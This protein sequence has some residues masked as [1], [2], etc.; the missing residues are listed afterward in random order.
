MTCLE[1]QKSNNNII[2]NTSVVSI[3]VFVV[4]NEIFT[5]LSENNEWREEILAIFALLSFLYAFIYI[6][7]IYPHMK[8]F[9]IGVIGLAFWAIFQ[10]VLIQDGG[11]LVFGIKWGAALILSLSPLLVIT[12]ANRNGYRYLA[13]NVALFFAEIYIALQLLSSYLFNFGETYIYSDGSTRAFGF[14][15]DSISPVIAFFV[16]K[17]LLEHRHYRFVIAF[18]CLMITGGK[19]AII[20]AIIMFF[21]MLYVCKGRKFSVKKYL[22]LGFVGYLILQILSISLSEGYENKSSPSSSIA[23][24]IFD[25]GYLQKKLSHLYGDYINAGGNR[26]FSIIAAIEIF[27]QN[28]VVGIGV[29][30]SMGFISSLDDGFPF[31][32]DFSISNADQ[33]W[34]GVKQI[35]NPTFRIMAEMG[36]IGLF[37]FWLVC[38]GILMIPFAYIRR[39]RKEKNKP[40]NACVLASALWVIVFVLFHQTTGWFE[41]GHPQLIWLFV[42]LGIVAAENI[43]WEREKKQICYVSH[44]ENKCGAHK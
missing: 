32:E 12:A 30:K 33:I 2:V 8:L 10:Q 34:A 41:P 16:I 39:I 4:V 24:K 15:S 44:V 25:A 6:K 29:N 35:H 31:I 11:S 5:L 3:L 40:I 37:L 13:I 17:N 26:L 9:L 23:V 1:S 27:Q 36:G 18:F 20:M 22:F 19:M 43:R 42:C 38:I 7:I 28:P 21:Y 14:L